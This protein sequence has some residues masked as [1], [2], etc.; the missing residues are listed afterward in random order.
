MDKATQE[1]L[2]KEVEQSAFYHWDC[3]EY[4][5]PNLSSG[6]IACLTQK[7]GSTACDLIEEGV[8]RAQARAHEIERLEALE[9]RVQAMGLQS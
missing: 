8:S 5:I 2:L 6:E 1:M 4:H 9:R 3:G 7:Y